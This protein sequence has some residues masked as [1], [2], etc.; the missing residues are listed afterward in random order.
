MKKYRW[1]KGLICIMSFSMLFIIACSPA[2]ATSSVP[3]VSS[4]T[5]T[6][7]ATAVSTWNG[8]SVDT[9]WY[10]SNPSASTYTISTAAELAGLAQLVNSGENII[11]KTITLTA[12]ID[13]SGRQWTPIGIYDPLNNLARLFN[14]TFDGNG[15][16]I[17]GLTI[18]SE[19]EPSSLKYIGLF[20][21]IDS[22]GV[23]Q[24]LTVAAS[25]IYFD[26]YDDDGRQASGNLAGSNLGTI[27]NC[28]VSGTITGNKG[29]NGQGN[30]S[31]VGGLIGYN[32]GNISNCSS[33]V[34]VK[35]DQTCVNGGLVGQ[36]EGNIIG[37]YATGNISSN[38]YSC[39]GGLAGANLG[40]IANCHATGD[41]IG[42]K[43]NYAGGLV[44]YL[45]MG[46]IM[47]C[48]ATGNVS[49]TGDKSRN[50]GYIGGLVGQSSWATIT[51][52]YATG[53]VS[54]SIYV[55]GLV[56]EN[57]GSLENCYAS[58]IV[59]GTNTSTVGG[60][61]GYNPAEITVGGEQEIA[62][63]LVNCYYNN[64]N[65][66]GIGVNDRDD[67]SCTGLTL[68]KMK[69]EVF[70]Q[71]LQSYVSANPSG[72]DDIALSSWKQSSTAQDGLPYLTAESSNTSPA[73]IPFT[74]V[75][76][77]E[78]SYQSI[79]YV[80]TYGWMNG[81]SATQFS[82]NQTLTRG[83]LVTILWRIAVQPDASSSQNFTD[84][85]ADSYCA[86]AV[87]WAVGEG[88][89]SGYGNGKF[90]PNNAITRE[91]LAAILYRYKDSPA[92][93]G[94][95]DFPDTPAS[96][97]WSYDALLWATQDG[98]VDG[99]ASGILN[100]HGTATRAEAAVMLYRLLA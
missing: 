26:L 8:S 28:T 52:S 88:I 37:C 12:D 99:T 60:L 96:G 56:G 32:Y 35:S 3:A 24:N 31:S 63:D 9:A 58:G 98:I 51:N 90:G 30:A 95:L 25:N 92:V 65:A 62:G 18:G 89:A 43:P 75:N 15:H 10:T 54:G 93:S 42:G 100:P 11:G 36:N 73:S 91:Q 34:D 48:Y 33:A 41:I 14:G 7:S 81:T 70:R 21:Y 68:T 86:Q 19:K 84:V 67:Q 45:G 2:T 29:V 1:K 78:W 80:Y 40:S 82:P 39:N 38:L 16:I 64:S 4:L 57:G 61:I 94:T 71:T 87:S 17:S 55:G 74:D 22:D 20:A 59:S 13:L 50:M 97:S 47:N 79:R 44:G 77:S 85:A 72:S 5:T 6:A 83:M 27:V 66:R 53:N 69:T 23:I 46:T 49:G 76:A